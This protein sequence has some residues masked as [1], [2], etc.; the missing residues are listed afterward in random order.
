LSFV[1]S[2]CWLAFSGAIGPDGSIDMVYGRTMIIG[3]FGGN[4]FNGQVW[5]PF[6]AAPYRLRL[7]RTG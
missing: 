5:Q 2:F 1:S 4:Q 6:L 3:N 7:S